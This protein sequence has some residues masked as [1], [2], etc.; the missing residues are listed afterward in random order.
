MRKDSGSEYRRLSKTLTRPQT[1]ELLAGM[2]KAPVYILGKTPGL[3]DLNAFLAQFGCQTDLSLLRP[4]KVWANLEEDIINEADK[5]IAQFI[6]S[7]LESP[8]IVVLLPPLVGLAAALVARMKEKCLTQKVL[9]VHYRVEHEPHF[10][11]FEL[12]CT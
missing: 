7:D 5:V 4:I 3:D 12:F 2:L 11:G 9:V 1:Q 6:K 8:I 10:V